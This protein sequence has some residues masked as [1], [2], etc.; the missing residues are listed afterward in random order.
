MNDTTRTMRAGQHPSNATTTT[1]R[2]AGTGSRL[3]LK[4]HLSG[5]SFDSQQAQLTPRESS[6]G[7][8]GVQMQRVQRSAPEGEETATSGSSGG[9]K[10][11]DL[12][13]V[14]IEVAEGALSDKFH[15]ALMKVAGDR[16]L[17]QAELE[18]LQKLATSDEDK[19][20]VRQAAGAVKSE[21]NA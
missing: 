2:V 3:Q 5:M 12:G 19:A 18:A 6:P 9:S 21:S 4:R 8:A 14:R 13:G 10:T 11:I 17:E 15:D 20:V 7:G 1:G 16:E